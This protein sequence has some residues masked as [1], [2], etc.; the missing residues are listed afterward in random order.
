[1]GNLHLVGG[2]KGGVGKSFTARLLAQY[3]IDSHS[4]FIGFDTDQ[5]NTTFSRFY[6]EFTQAV[7]V[8]EPESLDSIVSAA[9]QN[10]DAN[11]VVD[12]A[13]QTAA[14][15]DRWIADC[16]LFNL[17]DEMNYRVYYW[18]VIDHGADSMHLLDRLITKY[19]HEEL[20]LICVMNYG[21][22]KSFSDF[23]HSSSFSE[24]KERGVRFFN[25]ANLHEGLSHKIDFKS[26]SFWAAANNA[27]VMSIAER[28]RTKVWLK[29]NYEHIDTLLMPTVEVEP[30]EEEIELTP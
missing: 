14:K 10:P 25:L 13:A 11:I 8:D 17:L 27:E 3:F 24:A 1:M 30:S 5:S 15:I 19:G 12:L 16:D 2:E 4:H 9:E 28:Q 18:H 29:F 6:K 22:G 26:Y 21:R 20:T 7:N 23:E